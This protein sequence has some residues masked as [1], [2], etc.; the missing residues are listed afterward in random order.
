MYFITKKESETGKKFQKI[1]DKLKVCLEDQ[2]ALAD[3]YGFISWRG[4]H[5]EV[6]GGIS[7]VTFH[8]CTTVDAKLW[9]LVKGKTEYKPRLNTKEGKAVQADFDQ[10]TVITKGELNACIGWG[11]SFFKNIGLEWN[12][13]EYFCFKIEEDWTDVP[14]PSDCTEITTSKYRELF[15]KESRNED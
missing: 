6:A 12:K 13:D 1:V 8:K 11:E 5:W 14:I 4:A 3:K 2:K 9:K 15:K 10:A 7:S